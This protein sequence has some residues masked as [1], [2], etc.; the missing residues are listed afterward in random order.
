MDTFLLCCET[1]PSV[2]LGLLGNT[3]HLNILTAVKLGDWH[4]S[5]LAAEHQYALSAAKLDQLEYF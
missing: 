3:T 5:V 2:V 1:L 4:A